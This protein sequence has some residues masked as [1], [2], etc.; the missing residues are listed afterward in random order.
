MLFSDE[1]EKHLVLAVKKQTDS[2]SFYVLVGRYSNLF[3]SLSL[4]YSKSFKYLPLE[5]DDYYN[6]LI[7]IFYDLIQKYD[8]NSEKSF[9]AYIKVFSRFYLSNYIKK[10]LNKN[11]SIMNSFLLSEDYLNTT[12]DEKDYVLEDVFEI[13]FSFNFLSNLEKEVFQML[14]EGFSP[15]E[16]GIKMDKSTT[17]VYAII[18]RGKRKIKRFYKI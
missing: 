10:F 7:Y 13:I 12:I 9:P 11:N 5:Y 15:A 8:L 18:G 4:E 14:F 6:F 16:I 17:S 2:S 3:H 1:A